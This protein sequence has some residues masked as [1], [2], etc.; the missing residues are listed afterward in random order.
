MTGKLDVLEH[1]CI[2]LEVL[3]FLKSLS[4]NSTLS[5]LIWGL[6]KDPNAF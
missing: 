6:T 5:E 3:E 4:K 1:Q 2:F